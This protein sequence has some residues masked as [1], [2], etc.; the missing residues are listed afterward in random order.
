MRH[1]L[2]TATLISAAACVE[3]PAPIECETAGDCAATESCRDGTC[4]AN[5]G[6]REGEGDGCGVA[7][8]LRYE[9]EFL[10]LETGRVFADF[11]VD[12]AAWDVFVAFNSVRTPPGVVFQNQS[13]STLI[14]HTAT[15]FCDVTIAD[16]QELPF[17]GNL[18]DVPFSDTVVVLTASGNLFALGDARDGGEAQE[19]RFVAVD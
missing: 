16:A 7:V 4:H 2:F 5:E 11:E 13:V 12:G 6:E 3:T 1:A 9:T 17:N 18:I 19:L 10:D 15:P 8:S 14:T